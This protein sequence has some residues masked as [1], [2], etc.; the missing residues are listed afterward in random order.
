MSSSRGLHLAGAVAAAILL[1]L[2]VATGV[3]TGEAGAALWSTTLAVLA[4]V[5]VM[6]RWTRDTR[7][8]AALLA[9]PMLMMAY[10]LVFGWLAP[11]AATLTISLWPAVFTFVGVTLS[12]RTGLWLLP[13]AAVGI[14][15]AMDLPVGLAVP[16]WLVVMGLVVVVTQLPARLL[17]SIAEK[18]RHLESEHR[19]V[20]AAQRALAMS[21]ERFEQAFAASPVGMSLSDE[22]G[23]LVEVNRA[24]CDLLGRP[25]H[26]LLGRA[27]DELVHP[28]DRRA[29]TE[30]DAPASMIEQRYVR[31]DGA[32]RS[33]Q[34]TLAPVQGPG[35][36][37][38]T[39]AHVHDVTDRR[40]AE[41]AGARAQRV[42]LVL[43]DVAR[44]VVLRRDDVR[45]AVVQGAQQLTGATG[46]ALVE[47][48]DDTA[49]VVTAATERRQVGVQIA[50]S[51]LTMTATVWTRGEAV[52]VADVASEATVN[53]ALAQ[54]HTMVS[55]FW[56]PVRGPGGEVI[57]V[58]AASW[59]QARS[60]TSLEVRQAM[61]VLA[62]E[63]GAALWDQDARRRLEA[64][65]ILDPLTRLANRRGWDQGLEHLVAE[66]DRDG[67]QVAVA[68]VDLDHFKQYND[69]HGHAVGDELLVG[70]ADVLRRS[71][72]AHD[73]VC[74][75]GG[76]EFALA[77]VVDS[78]DQARAVMDRVMQA[79]PGGQTCSIG[80]ALHDVR[81]GVTDTLARADRA[82]YEVKRDGRH[83]VVVADA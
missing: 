54:L 70:L 40:L 18:Q 10:L 63:A 49:L 76:D 22:D 82:L 59:D 30:A 75:W 52:D 43:A 13:V 77:M 5:L 28:G 57:A 25:A 50:T 62:A 33:V 55:G 58:L 34:R 44:S 41:Q 74:R 15:T 6:W 51:D 12:A 65:A 80:L 17:A 53:P 3:S 72:R 83:R 81:A 61:E 16:R 23:R 14:W 7:S 46:V 24:L 19:D 47:S 64:S 11:Q 67:A 71:V 68:M 60:T 37:T 48:L 20:L 21:K 9:G 36:R 56:Q 32:V 66:A 8:P 38:W 73:L 35:H 39:L 26:E 27:D 69:A 42:S 1:G 29:G 4:L 31:P 78:A 2:A 79:V 45:D